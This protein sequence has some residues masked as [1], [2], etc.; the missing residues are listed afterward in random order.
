MAETF[1]YPDI[2]SYDGVAF[3]DYKVAMSELCKAMNYR[4]RVLKQTETAFYINATQTKANPEPSDFDGMLL[5]KISSSRID[6]NL[7]TLYSF[8][9]TAVSN[10][11]DAGSFG[12]TALTVSAL[13]TA[14]GYSYS[15]ARTDNYWD[16]IRW[17]WLTEAFGKLTRIMKLLSIPNPTTDRPR[18]VSMSGADGGGNTAWENLSDDDWDWSEISGQPI[19]PF[20][21]SYSYIGTTLVHYAQ[22]SF[23]DSVSEPTDLSVGST[24]IKREWSDTYRMSFSGTEASISAFRFTISGEEC[25]FSASGTFEFPQ[26]GSSQ[27]SHGIVSYTGGSLLPEIVFDAQQEC[28]VSPV[29]TYGQMHLGM[30]GFKTRYWQDI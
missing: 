5:M 25:F 13:N 4:Q 18:D 22:V 8:I 24:H 12:T 1:T 14:I 19:Q 28:P 26:S 6:D 21:I 17:A 30:Q 10:F 15:D 2:A 11:V 9:G 7:A 27:N 16:P 20:H 3:Q 23:Q 29:S